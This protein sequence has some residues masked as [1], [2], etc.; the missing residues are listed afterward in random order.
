M[1]DVLYMFGP[2]IAVIIVAGTTL[3]PPGVIAIGRAAQRFMV[4]Y[5]RKW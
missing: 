4:K 1:M 2:V 5:I 3:Q